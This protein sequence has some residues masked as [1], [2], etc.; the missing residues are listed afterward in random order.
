MKRIPWTSHRAST[1]SVNDLTN[2]INLRVAVS[3]TGARKPEF[4]QIFAAAQAPDP[5]PIHLA[6]YLRALLE[7]WGRLMFG[8]IF[9]AI[10]LAFV[11]DEMF[12]N[13]GN[14]VGL[15]VGL[16]P[17]AVC[18]AGGFD[19]T[20]RYEFA[21]RARRL[22]AAADGIQD[23]RIRSLTRM[24]TMG[25]GGFVLQLFVGLIVTAILV[26]Y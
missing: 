14:T 12:G 23:D 4:S 6:M 5:N 11:G 8:F 17:A 2:A 13:A 24:A 7:G 26:I 21:R 9:L 3:V 25:D 10:A 22:F 20:V 15:A 1:L 19:A 18:V 16:F